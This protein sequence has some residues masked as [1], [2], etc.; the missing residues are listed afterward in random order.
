MHGVEHHEDAAGSQAGLQRLGD[1]LGQALLHL[2]ARGEGVD[3]GG[4][5]AEADHPVARQVG[6]VGAADERQQV[7]LAD[8]AEREVAHE[9]ELPRGRADRDRVPQ[10]VERVDAEPGEVLAVGLGDASRGRL[11]AGPGDILADRGKELNDRG[12]DPRPVDCHPAPT[13]WRDAGCGRARASA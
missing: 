10:V 7:V 5:T 11:Q 13:R 1:L 2:R 12:L 8:G 6:Q 3:H 4:Q 9:H